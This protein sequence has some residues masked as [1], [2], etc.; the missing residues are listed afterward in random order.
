ML[1][2]SKKKPFKRKKHFK[3]ALMLA[4]FLLLLAS[5]LLGSW[6]LPVVREFFGQA[7]GT[8][9]AI[10]IQANNSLG[11]MPRPW[12]NLAQGGEDHNWRLAP[13]AGLVSELNPEYIRIDHI[14]DFYDIVAGTS[15]SL[16]FN[17]TK[18][19]LI[20]DD[21]LATG[22]KPYIAL[23]YMP[24]AI[25]SGDIVSPPRSY[26]DWQLTVQ[27][28]V[29]HISGTRGISDVYY[30]VW[31]EPDLF[32]GWKYSGQRNY[33]ELYSSAARGAAQAQ[34][35]KPFKIGGPATTALYKNWI[36]ALARHALSNNLRLDFISWHRYHRS[37]AQ[38]EQDLINLRSWLAAYPQLEATVELHLSEWGHESEN[39][40]GYDTTYSAAHTVA[41][42]ISMIQP[43]LRAFV[44]EIQDGKDPNGKAAWGRW[45][46]LQHQ[47]FGSVVKPRYQGLKMLDRLPEQRIQLSGNGTWVKAAAGIDEQGTVGIV[48][49]NFDPAERNFEVVP[50]S[51]SSLP[52]GQY[53]VTTTYLDGS[54]SQHIAETALRSIEFFVTM[55]VNSVSYTQLEKT[56]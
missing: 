35:V 23:S 20:I 11:P 17:F 56:Q 24:P 49:A 9:A 1:R 54:T 28:T 26:A 41:T 21:I 50:V 52:P 12:R 19:D 31:N 22:A 40:S 7:S 14:Y 16:T 34:N 18:L 15:G 13:V 46:F 55:P 10:L 6:Q 3:Q 47:S 37:P 2:S 44:F 39:D 51:I 53:T 25:S 8:P 27:R 36:D 42:A 4:A 38:F 33:L 48:M 43:G 29:E 32:G 45:G 5:T 30:E